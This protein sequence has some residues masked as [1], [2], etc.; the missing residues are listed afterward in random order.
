MMVSCRCQIQVRIKAAIYIL[1]C[2]LKRLYA[3]ASVFP[4]FFGLLRSECINLGI[5][6][7]YFYRIFFAH[8]KS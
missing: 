5:S 3:G 6:A 7:S 1:G 2:M 4:S 8:E